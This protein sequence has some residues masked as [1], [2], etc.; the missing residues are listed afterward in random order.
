[1]SDDLDLEDTS[2][3]EPEE[4]PK[5]AP[6]K[7]MRPKR[8]VGNAGALPAAVDVA[9]GA[10]APFRRQAS[11]ADAVWNELVAWLPSAGLT[12]R[13]IAIQ[14]RR[15]AP[16]APSGEP[17][18][19]GRAFGGEMVSGN[20]TEPPGS[21][22]VQFVMRY[23]HMPLTQTPASYDLMF[24]RKATGAQLA[25]GRLALPSAQDCQAMLQAG[26]QAGLGAPGAPPQ[27][28]WQPPPMYPQGPGL[29]Q[30]Y[31]WPSQGTGYPQ[32]Y[33]SAQFGPPPQP[34]APQGFAAPGMDPGVMNELAYLRGA[35]GEALNAAREGRQP[36]LP[37]SAPPPA[38]PTGTGGLTDLDVDRIAARVATMMGAV[39]KTVGAPPAPPP[40]VPTVAA[41]PPDS[42]LEGM[43]R[44]A[45]AGMTKR[46]FDT[47]LGSVEKSVTRSIG[48]GGL[49]GGSEDDGDEERPAPAEIIPPEKPED[50]VPWKVGDVG[51]NWSNGSPVKIAMNKETGKLDPMG[52]AFANPAVAEK[53]IDV[54]NGLGMALQDAIKNFGAKPGVGAP[55]QPSPHVVHSIPAGAVDATVGAS[56]DTPQ[57]IPDGWQA[58]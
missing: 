1:M 29:P 49:P 19:I 23:M 56:D 37:G 33:P 27:Q 14:V 45:V 17:L 22:L 16:P 53:L 5:P 2:E 4:T 58:P 39:A 50:M 9:P 28:M 13:D 21:A 6:R 25:T 43:M 54:A 40:S 48:I 57:A 52:L 46:I 36:N 47:A 55:P 3:E 30:G 8:G 38:A 15:V 20:N 34:T 24:M 51:A 18:P 42:S 11:E 41:P 31:P 12:P 26:E 32:T 35:L 44:T 10:P 7:S